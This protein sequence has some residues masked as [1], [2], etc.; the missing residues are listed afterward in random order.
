MNPRE[1]KREGCK[2]VKEPDGRMQD[3]ARRLRTVGL[4]LSFVSTGV[5][6]GK[7]RGPRT[8]NSMDMCGDPWNDRRTWLWLVFRSLSLL[9]IICE[10]GRTVVSVVLNEENFSRCHS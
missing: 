9:L 5:R 3:D 6:K 7:G 1:G 8:C 2:E 4:C 10:R